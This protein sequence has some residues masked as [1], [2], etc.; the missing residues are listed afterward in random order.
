MTVLGS[1][2]FVY[3]EVLDWAKLPAGWEFREVVDVAVDDQDRVYVFSRSDHPLMVFE[4]DGT[5]VRS[6]GEGLF[7]RPHGLTIVEDKE[8]G[9]VL[10]CVDDKGHWIG[11]FTKDGRLLAQIGERDKP[12]P[13]HGGMP[14]NQPTK[15][16][17]DLNTGELYISDGYSNA[18]V[19]KF[20]P[21]GRLLFSW[22][23]YGLENGEF[24]LPHSVCT[25]RAG[26]VYVADR[27]NHRIQLFD[28][29]GGYITQ[30]HNVH[31]PC[32]LFLHNNLAYVGQLPTHLDVNV[33]FPNLGGCITIHNLEGRTLARLGAAFPGEGP[34][35]FTAPH[36][37]AVDSH[38]DIYVGEVS[39]SAWG[40]RL[41]PPRL[42]RCFRKLV[43]QR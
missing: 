21:D 38:G 8:H 32:A 5:F 23:D 2:E 29:Q 40:R 25:D 15:V 6:W 14:F 13:A 3:A 4:Q 31:R 26:T 24:N 1:G 20:T 43:K 17:A 9:Q 16:A 35:Q 27:E 22:G 34:G 37:I 7:T 18:R 41:N 39:W 42:A 19:H 11:K 36:G 10:Y 28:S 30:W 12:A 33:E